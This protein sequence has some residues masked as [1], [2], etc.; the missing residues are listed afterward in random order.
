[1][2]S[3][4]TGVVLKQLT[5]LLLVYSSL[6]KS[7]KLQCLTDR[8]DKCC[9]LFSVGLADSLQECQMDGFGWK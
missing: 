1:M 6:I 7:A 2:V 8:F 4:K 5:P 3:K 9:K